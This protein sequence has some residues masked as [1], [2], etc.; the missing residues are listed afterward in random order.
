MLSLSISFFAIAL[1]YAAVGF[2]GGS[3]YIALL[4]VSNVPFELIPKVSLICNLLVVT[5]GTFLYYRNKHIRWDVALPLVLSS[6]PLSILGGLYP[7]K[8]HAFLVLLSSSLFLAGIRILFI[9]TPKIDHPG[10]PPSPLILVLT[11]AFLGALSGMVGIGGGIF[12]SPLMLNLRWARAKEAAAIASLFILL[13]SLGGL[14]GQVQKTG[15]FPNF[16]PYVWLFIAVLAGGQ[17]GSR[18][19]THSKV[20]HLWIQR[21]TGVL[22]LLVSGRLCL[23]LLSGA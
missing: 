21:A 16:G 11:G 23:K 17:I 12:L 8:E 7:I 4:A 15:G 10:T 3:S 1:L 5:G 2:G 22:I 18:I 9:K 14:I 20:S 13:N 6:L 19:G